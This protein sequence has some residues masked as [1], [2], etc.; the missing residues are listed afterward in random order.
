MCLYVCVYVSLDVH[1]HICA[2]VC[3][4]VCVLEYL[5]GGRGGGVSQANAI[6]D[7]KTTSRKRDLALSSGLCG[8]Q[9]LTW[10]IHIDAGKAIIHIK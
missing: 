8:H 5:Y 9:A 10:C 4:H 7:W 6:G 3:V 2:W 1:V